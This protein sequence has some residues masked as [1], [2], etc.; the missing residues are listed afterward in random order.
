[1]KLTT[2]PRIFTLELTE[3]EVYRLWELTGCVSCAD[4]RELIKDCQVTSTAEEIYQ[5]TTALYDL[6]EEEK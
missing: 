5:T 4:V 2:P 3:K 6:L 1:M